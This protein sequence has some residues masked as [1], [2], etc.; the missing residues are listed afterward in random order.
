MYTV[1]I[2]RKAQKK[3]EKISEPYYSNI[4]KAILEINFA[5]SLV[6]FHI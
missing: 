1:L 2:E 3:L 4:K 6:K 5:L